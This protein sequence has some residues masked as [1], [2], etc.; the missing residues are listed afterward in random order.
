MPE[1]DLRDQMG[2]LAEKA[3]TLARDQYQ[4]NLDYSEDSLQLVEKILSKL[5]GDIPKGLFGRLLRRGPTQ[6]Q[7]EGICQLMG[8]YLGEVIRRRWDGTWHMDSTFGMPLPALSVLGGDIYPTNKVYKRLVDGEGDNL[9]SYYQM[10]KH[11]HE[12]GAPSQQT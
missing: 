11:I 8:A 2:L 1:N 4:T 7:I 9:W 5:S 3:V 10:L 6:K 12:H